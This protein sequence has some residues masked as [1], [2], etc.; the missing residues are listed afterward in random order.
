MLDALLKPTLEGAGPLYLTGEENLRLTTFGSLA[1]AVVAL[2]GRVIRP[3]GTLSI[4]AER[5]IASTT[6][7]AASNIF[8]LSEG[9]LSTVSLRVS[10]GAALRGHVYAILELVRGREGAVQPCA[11]LLADY[12]QANAR[13]T[14]P[15]SPVAAPTSGS[16]LVRT[17]VGTNPAA[18]VEIAETVPTAA[19]WR[20]RTF[21]YT[22]VA[23]GAAANRRPVLTIDDG[24]NILWEAF[25]NVAQTLGQTVKYRA[26]VGVPFLLYDTLAYQVPLPAEF[27]LLAGSR[28]RTVTAAI[29]A[30]D[31]YAA[32]IYNLEEWLDP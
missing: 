10:T 8:P 3:D 19:R 14:W 27:V 20:L 24:A 13:L 7:A 21:N 26:G 4:I 16:G 5:H 17:I 32:P 18:G 25:T 28:I 29:D 12:V 2:E 23:S 9:F 30:G 1:G 31:D 22:L 6:R 11:T 15:G